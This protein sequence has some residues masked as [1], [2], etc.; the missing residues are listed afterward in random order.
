MPFAVLASVRSQEGIELHFGG[1]D[2]PMAAKGKRITRDF[3]FSTP[4]F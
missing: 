4:L 3:R 1:C 2:P